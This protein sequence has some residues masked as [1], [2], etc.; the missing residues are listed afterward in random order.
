MIET[1]GE[2][3]LYPLLILP[4]LADVLLTLAGK[5]RHGIGF[6]SP[7]R[8]HAYQLLA[9]TGWPH[10]RVALAYFIAS[11]VCALM[12]VLGAALGGRAPFALFAAGVAV[13]MVLHAGI[14]RQAARSGLD[15]K[16]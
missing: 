5:V 16:S 9:R 2:V 10:W 14:R 4:V 12:A 13:A 6:L 8:T 11:S 3:W 7:H 1:P 15:L